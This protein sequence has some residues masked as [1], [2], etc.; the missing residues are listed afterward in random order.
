MGKPNVLFYF[1]QLADISSQISTVGPEAKTELGN[2]DHKP[3]ISK[4]EKLA[5]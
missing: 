5:V 3:S 1:G 2:H 4:S